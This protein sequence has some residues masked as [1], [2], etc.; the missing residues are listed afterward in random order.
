MMVDKPQ[1]LETTR[2]SIAIPR[3]DSQEEIP[4]QESNLKKQ[5]SERE[6]VH[7]NRARMHKRQDLFAIGQAIE[8]RLGDSCTH[9]KE[10]NIH[11][12]PRLASMLPH[13]KEYG[14][15]VVRNDTKIPSRKKKEKKKKENIN[16]C[17]RH[18]MIYY[19]DNNR[20]AKSRKIDSYN[21]QKIRNSMLSLQLYK[22]RSFLF[23]FL[24]FFFFPFFLLMSLTQ[25]GEQT[26]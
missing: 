25:K 11:V 4:L 16:E 5:Y 1:L 13:P 2:R 3:Y 10:Q 9:S 7:E 22:S 20:S 8:Y 23:F 12:H 14:Y 26:K 18:R 19:G 6:R 17:C 24:F 21:R 15:T